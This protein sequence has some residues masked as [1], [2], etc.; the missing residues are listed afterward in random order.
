MVAIVG[1][2]SQKGGVGKT[3][4]SRALAREAAANGLKVKIADLDVQQGTAVNWQRRRLSAGIEPLVSVESFKTAKQA[5]DSA[6]GYDLLIIDGPARASDATLQIAKVADLIVQPSGASLDDLEPAIITFNNLVKENIPKTKLIFALNRVGTEAEQRNGEEYLE[7]ARF[8]FLG[9]CLFEKPAYRK[10]QNQG[11][12]V[13]ETPY[14]SLNKS[15][16]SFIQEL[17][18]RI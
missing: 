11:L 17:V 12:S 9:G 10:A 15:A 7:K 14:S 3:T 4:L 1:F 2:I 8:D 6:S 16:D 5:I 13:T 18:N